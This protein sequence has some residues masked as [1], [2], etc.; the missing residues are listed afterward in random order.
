MSS[1]IQIFDFNSNQVRIQI[2]NNKEYFC[3]K[4][5]CDILGYSNGRDAIEKHCKPRGVA[6]RDTLTNGGMQQ[7]SYIDE[8]NLY[9][10]ISHSK[11]PS[12]EKFEAWVFE[13]IL[14]TIRKTGKFEVR[15]LSQKEQVLLLAKNLIQ[16]EEE[17]QRLQIENT[18]KEE[19]IE[20][21]IEAKEHKNYTQ[22]ADI[23]GMPQKK[24]LEYLRSNGYVE[25][26]GRRQTV[27]SKNL[28]IIETKWSEK[29]Y[30]RFLVTPKGIEYFKRKISLNT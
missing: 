26:N 13:E 24:F 25:K 30:E 5:V 21:F 20:K 8:P 1:Q 4:D 9:R 19:V 2:I 22:T 7:L 11:L 17:N 29:G 14:P 6:K 12:A 18:Q 3:A 16:A 27:K 23:I 10:L 15:Q 28:K